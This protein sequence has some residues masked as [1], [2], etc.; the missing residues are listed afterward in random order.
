[1]TTRFACL[2]ILHNQARWHLPAPSHK[3]YPKLHHSAIAIYILLGFN[4]AKDSPVGSPHLHIL[5]CQHLSWSRSK[6]IK[7]ILGC[8]FCGPSTPKTACQWL[9]SQ[10]WT[11]DHRCCYTSYLLPTSSYLQFFTICTTYYPPHCSL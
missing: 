3:H 6:V 4:S 7:G 10:G 11:C 2:L 8:F 1:M 5:L 9:A